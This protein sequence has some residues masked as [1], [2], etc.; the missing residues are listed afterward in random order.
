MTEL[1]N[2]EDLRIETVIALVEMAIRLLD[3]DHLKA[4]KIGLEMYIANEEEKK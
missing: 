2:T 4:L 1:N 3:L